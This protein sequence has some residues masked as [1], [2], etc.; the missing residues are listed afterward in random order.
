MLLLLSA[1]LAIAQKQIFVFAKMDVVAQRARY[2]EGEKWCASC[3]PQSFSSPAQSL[4]AV[5]SNPSASCSTKYSFEPY[6]LPFKIKQP[7]VFGRTYKSAYF[8]AVILTSIQ[9]QDETG[10]CRHIEESARL[11]AQALFPQ[12]KVFA[13]HFGCAEELILYTN[14]NQSFNFMGIYAGAT[15][16]EA[17]KMLGRV[18]A[19]GRFPTANI[20]RMQVVLEFST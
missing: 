9:A 14:V 12:R 10:E 2:V 20:R 3:A 8:Y 17:N 6:Q 7:L 13:S 4:G 18:R 5:C 1:D 16:A 15:K 11:E 19:T